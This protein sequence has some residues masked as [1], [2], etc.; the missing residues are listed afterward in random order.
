MVAGGMR[1]PLPAFDLL[2]ELRPR[3][4]AIYFMT[5][6]AFVNP[7][8]VVAEITR[9][10]R[11]TG[12]VVPIHCITFIEREAEETMKEIARQSGGSYTHV[13]GGAP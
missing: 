6:G 11:S 8:A 10:N 1:V 4:D 12:R 5:D 9:L 2:F 3:P 7:E 13:T